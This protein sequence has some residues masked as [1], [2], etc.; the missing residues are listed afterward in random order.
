[1]KS[2]AK[3]LMVILGGIGVVSV[4]AYITRPKPAPT[5]MEMNPSSGEALA[6]NDLAGNSGGGTISA[7]ASSAPP[8]GMTASDAAALAPE[9]SRKFR[10]L[11]EILLSKND[12]D[13]RLDAEL[14]DFT[15]AAKAAIRA[16][17]ESTRPE[18]R[19]ERGTLVFLLGR[20][21]REPADLGFFAGV[22]AEKPCLSLQDCNRPPEAHSGEEEHFESINETTANY[23]QLMAL[24]ALKQRAGELLDAEAKGSA[25]GPL[26]QGILQT[27]RAGAN[28]AN[29]KVSAELREI[30][31]ALEGRE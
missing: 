27:L 21:I 22:L 29:A 31:E 18:H 13:P 20:E 26:Y 16:R 11:D 30:L 4:A 1:M 7:G 15:P 6:G 14:K 28:S 24:R 3:L 23:P 17:Y 19:N 12:N 8:A 5:S 10:I 9:D 25:R 2:K